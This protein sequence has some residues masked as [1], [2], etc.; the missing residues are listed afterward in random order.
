[1]A[2]YVI[3]P[4][5]GA[6]TDFAV[7]FPYL[8]TDHVKVYASGVA[9][10]PAWL[11]SALIRVA[12]AVASGSVLLIA[13]ET[14]KTPMTV[15]ENT[16]NLTA[17]NL[18]LA[19][20]QALF[21]AEEASDRAEQSII[22][23]EATGQYDFGNRR[24][25]NVADP[26]ND[27][28]A[29]TMKWATTANTSVLAQTIVQAQNAAASAAQADTDAGY[30]A[31]ERLTISGWKDTISGWKDTI[32]G[33]YTAIQAWYNSVNTW[34][35]QVS[36]DK[37]TVATDKATVA[38]DKATVA[39]DKGSVATDK[40]IVAGYKSDAATSA[41]NAATSAA[42][43]AASAASVD[44]TNI[45][46]K[47]G[48]LS[49]LAD[50]AAARVNL[51]LGNIATAN[52]V[53]LADLRT[54]T[55]QGVITTDKAWSAAGWVALGNSGSGNLN[56]DCN[57]GSR[58][59]ATLT[60]NVTVN[61]LNPKDGQAVE[62][63]LVQDAT[64]GRTVSWNSNIRFPNATAPVV[65]TAANGWA[66]VFSGVYVSSYSQWQGSGWKVS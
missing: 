24:A 21:I 43:A 63:A 65:A 52:G 49:G 28:D 11:N 17:E 2:S 4:G 62:I 45:L 47:S 27:Q 31:A 32:N 15:F 66:V 34:Q 60:G 36:A 46:T 25:T 35:A 12:P 20:T 13:R 3:Y 39:A 55:G 26:V 59:T 22:V 40:G 61:L 16:N 6:Q 58:F 38:A 18:T 42:A 53:V 51:G 54:N 14:V 29:V 9:V 5:D 44:G 37:S 48:N 33:W 30:A 23:S 19:E 50:S 41:S 64:G 8:S 56:I 7:P 1:M 57:L 10:T